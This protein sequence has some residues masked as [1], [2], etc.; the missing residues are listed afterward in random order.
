MIFNFNS[1]IMNPF[2]LLFAA[3]FLGLLFGKVRIGKF[4]FGLSGALFSGI[5]LGWSILTYAK[6]IKSGSA[7]YAIAQQAVSKGLISQDL[8][9]L[10]LILF[11]AAVGLIAGKDIKG[12][13][14]S[15]GVKL[16]LIGL[17]ITLSGAS[18]TYVFLKSSKQFDAHQISGI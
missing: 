1:F 15:Y 5:A 14:K 10:F 4:S 3:V 12:I 6:H 8:F 9:N 11:I 17:V 18:L 2:V 16:I 7:E 13:L